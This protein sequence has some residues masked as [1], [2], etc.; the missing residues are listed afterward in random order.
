MNYDVCMSITAHPNINAAGLSAE[1]IGLIVKYS[2]GD[3]EGTKAL[4]P[5]VK[6]LVESFAVVLSETLD[7]EARGWFAHVTE[8]EIHLR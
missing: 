8:D 7:M 2:R 3:M 5:R 6:E 4:T 1:L